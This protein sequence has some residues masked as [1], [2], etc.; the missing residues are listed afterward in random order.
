MKRVKKIGIWQKKRNPKVSF[1]SEIS[2]FTNGQFIKNLLIRK[3]EAKNSLGGVEFIWI[4]KD[5]GEGV[6]KELTDSDQ[7]PDVNST[8]PKSQ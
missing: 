5:G 3:G 8:K 4:R 6:A 1:W 7:P 2:L